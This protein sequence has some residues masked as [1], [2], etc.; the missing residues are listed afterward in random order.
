MLLTYIAA[1]IKDEQN[2]VYSLLASCPKKKTRNLVTD[3]S[4]RRA[5]VCFFRRKYEHV[6]FVR[7]KFV[8]LFVVLD[9]IFS[10]EITQLIDIPLKRALQICETR[11]DID[12][13]FTMNL[14]SFTH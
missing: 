14:S 10:A 6:S 1:H 9:K 11:C 5:L 12:R 8:M 3:F 4:C 7:V 13:I 2:W